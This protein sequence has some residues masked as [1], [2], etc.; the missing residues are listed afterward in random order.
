MTDDSRSLR[1]LAEQHGVAGERTKLAIERL[2]IAPLQDKY[3][4]AVLRPVRDA[5]LK[6]YYGTRSTDLRQRQ[7]LLFGHPEI[8]FMQ[9]AAELILS[10]ATDAKHAGLLTDQWMKDERANLTAMTDASQLPA[11]L[12]AA[13]FGRMVTSDV[14][15]NVDAAIHV[16][17]AFTVHAEQSE[18]D[19]FSVVDD[20]GA[21]AEADM[22]AAGLFDTELTTGLYY[23]YVVIDV[24]LLVSNLT[25]C[26]RR[27]WA[28]DQDRGLAAQVVENLI[29]LIAEVSPGAKRG[30]TAPY[31]RAEMVLVEAGDRQPRTLANAFREPVPFTDEMNQTFGRRTTQALRSHLADL[32]ELYATGEARC[33]MATAEMQLDGIKK[34]SLLELAS[35][36][37]SRVRDAAL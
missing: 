15:A 9:R 13:L 23:G 31:G 1:R 27:E 25:G 12:E 11:S 16:A 6:R 29:C 14:R 17:H 20:L 26:S 22:V 37:G 10:Q 35:W 36:T 8:R 28:G 19:F 7:A 5:F 34:A 32:D 21:I 18:T 2:V 3:P 24:P 30:S 4:E 33:H